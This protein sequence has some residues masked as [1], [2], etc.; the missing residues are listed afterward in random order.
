MGCQC[1]VTEILGQR[2]HVRRCPGLDGVPLQSRFCCD[3]PPIVHAGKDR[4][5]T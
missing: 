4:R 3:A 2:V 5:S 1:A